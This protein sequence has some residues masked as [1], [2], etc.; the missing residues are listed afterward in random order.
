AIAALT[1]A[2]CSPTL[3]RLLDTYGPRRIVLPCVTVFGLGV[4]SLALLGPRLWQFYASC[5][6]IGV[7]GNG[8]AQMGYA[9]AVSSW[10][11]KR[12]GMALALVMA[13]TGVGAIVLPFLAQTLISGPGWRAAYLV[14]G[15]L[16]LVQGLPLTWRYVREREW[17]RQPG[18]GSAQPGVTW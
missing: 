1:V 2:V 8:T 7:V 3:G 11:S 16:V 10:F 18:D 12:L 17:D 14:L 15:I 6:L 5:F 4:A 9:R 13:G